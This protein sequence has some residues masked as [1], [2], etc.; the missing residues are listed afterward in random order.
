MHVRYIVIPISLLLFC[1]CLSSCHRGISTS[2]SRP[3]EERSQFS[4]EFDLSSDM[5][6]CLFNKPMIAVFQTR[7]SPYHNDLFQPE[8]TFAVWDN[9]T[10]LLKENRNYVTGALSVQSLLDPH[11]PDDFPRFGT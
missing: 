7:F 11:F 3:A 5:P 8:I 6:A 1:T 10:F 9:G 2:A 4:G